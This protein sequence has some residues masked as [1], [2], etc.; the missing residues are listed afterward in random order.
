MLHCMFI[1]SLPS[2]NLEQWRVCIYLDEVRR[3]YLS[4]R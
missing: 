3:A 2:Y 4:E 1:Y